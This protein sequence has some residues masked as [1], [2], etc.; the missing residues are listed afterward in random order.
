MSGSTNSENSYSRNRY[1]LI[2]YTILALAIFLPL[3]RPG[4]IL[5]LDNVWSPHQNYIVDYLLGNGIGGQFPFLVILQFIELILP[6][7]VTQKIILFSV[8]LIAGISAHISAPSRSVYGKYFCGTLYAVNPFVYSRF[9]AGHL[10]IL[11]AYAFVPLAITS[12]QEFLDDNTKWKKPLLW[13]TVISIFSMHILLIVLLIQLCIFV[14]AIV[15]EKEGR[16][17]L[18]RSTVHLGLFYLAVNMFWILPV[19]SSVF[20]ESTALNQIST[21]DLSAFTSSST[22]SGNIL[23]SIA[24]MYG[25]WRGGYAYPFHFA[26]KWVFVILFIGILFL[27]IHGF[28]S[29]TKKPLHKGLI[30]SGIISFILACGISY[31]YFAPIFENLF[32]HLFIFKGMR[33]SQKF[34]GALVLVYSFL[35]SLGVDQIFKSFKC[36][37]RIKLIPEKKQKIYSLI[38]AFFIILVPIAYSFTIF[39]G[40]YGQVEPR[41]YPSEWYEANEF[42]SN[43]TDDFDVLF[44]PW[45]MY[46]SF[47][48]SERRIANPAGIFFEKPTITKQYADVGGVQTQSSNPIQHYIGYLV[49]HKNE[50]NNFGELIVPLNTKYVILA[51]DVDYH[52]YDFLYKQKDLEVVMENEKLVIFEN[53]YQTSR[54]REVSSLIRLNNWE[55]LVKQS[56]NIEINNYGYVMSSTDVEN[57]KQN[58]L[59]MPKKELNLIRISPLRYQVNDS[60]RY[61]VFTPPNHN[62]N[63]WALGDGKDLDSAGLACIFETSEPDNSS[64]H[65]YYKPLIAHLT[66]ILISIVTILILL[67][68]KHYA[69]IK[70]T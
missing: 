23:I 61:I 24:M 48:W 47:G 13:N 35:G 41:D 67:I 25:F 56:K 28:L 63:G 69:R 14:F 32:N 21:I 3:L 8:F 54:A 70:L 29:N 2:Y 20:Q 33:D 62:I 42:L 51:K 15:D 1:A 57:A 59:N 50:I 6:S 39:N 55:D 26:P 66:G 40:F 27:A 52:L 46:M 34:V 30:L 22:I 68:K 10:Y 44:F 53:V 37:N 16:K 9:L 18:I 49:N 19:F 65:I 45:H 60:A 4:Y 17:N 36:N 58:N 11:L 12:F 43:D 31:P 7:W 38:L 64:K 5:T